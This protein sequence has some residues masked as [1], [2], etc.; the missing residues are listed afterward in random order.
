MNVKNHISNIVTIRLKSVTLLAIL[1]CFLCLNTSVMADEKREYQKP[2]DVVVWLYHDF[3]W[4]AVMSTRPSNS[5]QLYGQP[6]EI[7]EGYLSAELTTLI[8]NDQKCVEDSGE[9]C[10]IDFGILWDSQ[11]PIAYDLKISGADTNNTIRV[12]YT[13]INGENIKIDFRVEEFEHGWRITD[14]IYKKGFSLLEI[15][16]RPIN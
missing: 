9:P 14:I 6:R 1:T 12:Q 7:L 8:L 15:L 16:R 2:E 3:A 11:D 10:N 5:S 4:E 13:Y